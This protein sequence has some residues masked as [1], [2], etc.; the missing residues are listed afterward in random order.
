MLTALKIYLRIKKTNIEIRRLKTL[1][2]N[3][4]KIIKINLKIWD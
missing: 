3:N 1:I 4:Y 2:T